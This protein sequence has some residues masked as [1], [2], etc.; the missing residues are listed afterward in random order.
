MFAS[1]LR[2]YTCDAK[3]AGYPRLAFTRDLW[4][5]TY[6]GVGDAGSH[7]QTGLHAWTLILAIALAVAAA[8]YTYPSSARPQGQF[9]KAGSHHRPQWPVSVSIQA[10]SPQRSTDSVVRFDTARIS[11]GRRCRIGNIAVGS[12]GSNKADDH[13]VNW[14]GDSVIVG[15]V[16]VIPGHGLALLAESVWNNLSIVS[17]YTTMRQSCLQK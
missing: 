16:N 9:R 1:R 12:P 8:L 11:R 15:P 4:N 17:D 6:C 5:E 10:P 3:V 7:Y 2:S 13:L 14:Q